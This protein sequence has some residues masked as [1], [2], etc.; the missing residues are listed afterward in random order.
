MAWLGMNVPKCEAVVFASWVPSTSQAWWGSPGRLIPRSGKI[1]KQLERRRLQRL[2][3]QVALVPA[4][5]GPGCGQVH[6]ASSRSRSTRRSL[7]RSTLP[8]ERLA[9]ST[10]AQILISERDC[11]MAVFDHGMDVAAVAESGGHLVLAV[12]PRSDRVTGRGERRS[13]E[14]CR[15][16]LGGLRQAAVRHEVAECTFRRCSRWRRTW[17]PWAQ[18]ACKTRPIRALL[19]PDR[20]ASGRPLP[21]GADGP[22]RLTW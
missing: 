21:G 8:S 4:P 22:T 19:P 9:G 3:Q 2:C 6:R 14:T 16:Q 17:R 11:N 18:L 1:D 5:A 15:A 20:Q 7:S 10:S 12:R 13:S